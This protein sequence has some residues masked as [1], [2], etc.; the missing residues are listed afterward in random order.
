[1]EDLAIQLANTA[2]GDAPNE[3]LGRMRNK[4]PTC[5]LAIFEISTE[6]WARISP[7]L[8]RLVSFST[9]KDLADSAD[10]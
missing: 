6:R 4:F 7:D 2:A 5:T 8:A 10:A 1:M 9:P 3:M